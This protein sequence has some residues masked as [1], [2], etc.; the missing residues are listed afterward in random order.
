MVPRGPIFRLGFHPTGSQ[1]VSCI[2]IMSSGPVSGGLVSSGPVSS[3][4]V[5][6]G[7]VSG[8]DNMWQF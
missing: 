1:E 3:G 4:P 8:G 7:P 6:G 2:I 5:S